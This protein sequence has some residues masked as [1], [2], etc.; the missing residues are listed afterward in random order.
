MICSGGAEETPTPKGEF[1][2]SQKIEYAWV[3]RFNMGAFYWIRFYG[4]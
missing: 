1:V 4:S 2:T 3:E